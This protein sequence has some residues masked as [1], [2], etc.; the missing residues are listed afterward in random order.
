MRHEK[1]FKH[2]DGTRYRIMVSLYLESYTTVTRWTHD[3][4]ACEPGKRKFKSI[5]RGGPDAD[6]QI[7]E[8]KMELWNKLKPE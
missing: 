7:L 6:R 1:I 4:Y 8:T 3:Q 2:P 5:L